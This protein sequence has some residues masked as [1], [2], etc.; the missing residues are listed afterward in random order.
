MPFPPLYDISFIQ[1]ILPH[2]SPFLFV[3]RILEIDLGKRI[4]AE[5]DLT[6]DAPFFS[7]HFPERPVMPGVLVAEALAQ[8]SGL[9]LGVTWKER[10]PSHDTTR[11]DLFLANVNIK[12]TSLC[13]PGDTLRLEA[14]LKKEF[15]RLY[16][17]AVAAFVT[18]RRVAKGSL[19]LAEE[20]KK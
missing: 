4:V 8:T 17:F 14:I 7:G 18:H 11:R 3:N 5:N 2:R 19:M 1:D 9:L 10:R 13:G 20:E 15:G 12:F 6:P 16:A